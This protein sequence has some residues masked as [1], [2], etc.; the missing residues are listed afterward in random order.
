MCLMRLLL[1]LLLLLLLPLLVL[2]RSIN[3]V[4]ATPRCF[5]VS[6]CLLHCIYMNIYRYICICCAKKIKTTK[7]LIA[8]SVKISK[9]DK[10]KISKC[11]YQR[12]CSSSNFVGFPPPTTWRSA[13]VVRDLRRHKLTP[14]YID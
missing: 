4:P 8:D 1:L 7:F 3:N 13:C 5:F 10:N 11:F 6:C 9:C 14:N 12:Q 2:C